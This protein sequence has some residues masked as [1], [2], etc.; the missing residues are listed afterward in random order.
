MIWKSTE[1]QGTKSGYLYVGVPLYRET[2]VSGYLCEGDQQQSGRL[3]DNTTTDKIE[4]GYMT[5]TT[6]CM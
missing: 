1:F 4:R 3:S 2:S 5:D 6:T